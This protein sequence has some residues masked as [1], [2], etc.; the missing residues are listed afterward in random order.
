MATRATTRTAAR[1]TATAATQPRTSSAARNLAG[2]ELVLNDAGIGGDRF[3]RA[4]ATAIADL[5]AGT[6][7]RVD[8][9]ATQFSHPERD[10]LASGG[11]D[12]SPHRPRDPDPLTETAARFAALLAD[13]DDV[14]AVA[15]RLGVTRARVRQRALDR[16]LFAIREDDEWRFPR[17]QF[18]DGAPI[19]GLPAVSI[20]MPPD[21][22]PVAAWRFLTEPT[23]D[24]ELADHPTTPLDWL[25]SGGSPDPVVAIAREL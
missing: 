9:P 19:R 4:A 20:A 6:G 2:L 17:A 12:L 18:A 24:L 10:I 13:S 8:E 14:A 7:P 23:V 15:E 16:S 25:R 22:H 3:T 5:R 1:R 11:L 21:L